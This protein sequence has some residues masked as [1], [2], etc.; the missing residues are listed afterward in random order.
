MHTM[1]FSHNVS[2]FFEAPT[3]S[4][5]NDGHLCGQSC[6]RYDNNSVVRREW[7]WVSTLNLT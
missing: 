1:E 3:M 4:G 2:L 6:S 7:V 5:M